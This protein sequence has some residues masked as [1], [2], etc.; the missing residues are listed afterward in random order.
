MKKIFLLILAIIV[1]LSC[2]AG[3]GNAQHAESE[4]TT[5]TTINIDGNEEESAAVE[6]FLMAIDATD[7]NVVT[8]RDE[9]IRRLE[10]VNKD[11]NASFLTEEERLFLEK[12]GYHVSYNGVYLDDFD[13]SYSELSEYICPILYKTEENDVHLW[14]VDEYG[15]V[16][17]EAITG[18]LSTGDSYE[19]LGNIHYTGE[20]DSEE[21]VEKTDWYTTVYNEST[22][23]LSFWE[24]GKLGCEYKVP[25]K[26]IYAGLSYWEGYIFRSGTDIYAV[27]GYGSYS[28]DENESDNVRVIAHNVKFVIDASYKMGSDD[29]SQPLFLMEDGTVKG[30]CRWRGDEGAPSD[31]TSYLYEIPYEGGYR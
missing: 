30:Y 6:T 4:N 29:W 21:I 2:L 19:Y 25:E 15:N 10:V 23:T 16:R 28:Q 31:D 3:C 13:A 11:E 1:C 17:A 20:S 24:F 9:V 14:Y 12:E 22:G 27:Y 26:A 5:E 7:E 18:D 8:Y